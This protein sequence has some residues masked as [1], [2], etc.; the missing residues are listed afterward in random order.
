[1]QLPKYNPKKRRVTLKKCQ[2]PGCGCEF[3]GHP[4]A[5][6]CEAHKDFKTRQKTKKLSDS[7]EVRNMFFKHC[8]SDMIEVKFRCCLD[9]CNSV[10]LVKILPKQFIYP[11]FCP[12]HRNDFKRVNYIRIQK[13]KTA[14]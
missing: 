12:I 5:K 9:G 1:M 3:W 13:R 2:E 11:R 8:Y 6:Y 7:L 10:F 14:E 4:I